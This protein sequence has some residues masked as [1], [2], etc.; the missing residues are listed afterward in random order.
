MSFNFN[1]FKENYNL[2]PLDIPNKEEYYHDLINIENSWTGRVDIL[3]ANTFIQEAVQ[4]VINAISLFEKGYFDCAYYSLRQSLEVS[5]TMIYL[6][7]LDYH[8]KEDELAKWKNQSKFPMYGQMIK[9][10]NDNSNVFSNMTEHMSNYFNELRTAKER[11]N[12]YVHKQGFN[13]FYVFRNHIFNGNKSNNRLLDEFN[14]YIRICIGA[15]AVLRLAID[16]YPI[17]LMD[18]DV[19][20]RIGD[21]LTEAYSEEFVE[22]YIGENNINAYKNTGVYKNY[23]EAIM[24]EEAMLPCVVELVKNQY[25]DRAKID[26]ILSQKHLISKNDIITVL[27]SRYSENVARIYCNR[28]LTFYFTSTKSSRKNLG[29]DGR[30]FEKIRKLNLH[31]NNTYEEAFL[32]Y[33]AFDNEE[34]YIEHNKKF[35]DSEIDELLKQLMSFA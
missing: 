18:Y 31:V 26:D 5:T 30:E 1:E 20:I 19:Y 24:N 23:Y 27:I 12:K 13:T 2:L 3:M 32:T 17:L 7:E 22:K 28:G 35:G 10:I 29:Y 16:P 14:K 21:T 9:Y 6:S 11:L 4:L 8:K 33:I 15:I 25:I 34:Y